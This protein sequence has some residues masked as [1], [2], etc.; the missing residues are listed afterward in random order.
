M[1][2][3][4]DPCLPVRQNKTD[5]FNHT[6]PPLSAQCSHNLTNILCLLSPPSVTQSWATLVL[7]THHPHST[8]P[9]LSPL[10]YH[11]TDP[12]DTGLTQYTE[13]CQHWLYL[14]PLS[15]TLSISGPLPQQG[16]SNKQLLTVS[17]QGDYTGWLHLQFLVPQFSLNEP[18]LPSRKNMF[19]GQRP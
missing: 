6:P 14:L 7:K 4:L 18:V 16:Q 15:P 11:P 19:A 17:G 8:T 10:F 12:T 1:V 13:D 9:T 5:C 2:H 3:Y